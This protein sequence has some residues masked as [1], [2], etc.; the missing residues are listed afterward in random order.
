MA[1]TTCRD[2]LLKTDALG[3]VTL[4]R[5]KREALLDEFERGGI[6]GPKFAAMVGVKYQTFA[7]WM[8]RRR[9]AR[10][11]PTLGGVKD[12][13]GQAEGAALRWVEAVAPRSAPAETRGAVALRVCLPGGASLEIN[14]ER[15]V[16]LAAALLRALDTPG[17]C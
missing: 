1:N 12:S 5:H 17:P 2:E 10:R 8:Q 11:S 7:D 4:P 15:V 13:G 16:P 9:Q 3:R 6:S 14:D